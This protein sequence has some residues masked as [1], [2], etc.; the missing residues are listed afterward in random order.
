MTI[1]VVART[2]AFLAV[3]ALVAAC[4][5]G[6]AGPVQA[7]LLLERPNGTSAEFSLGRYD[8]QENCQRVVQNEVSM[9]ERDHGGQFGTNPQFTYGGV[10]QQGWET[11]RLIGSGC[12]AR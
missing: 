8:S 7:Y 12:R 3:T 2:L 9:I 1:A 10:P 6:R 4:D 5:D 11:N